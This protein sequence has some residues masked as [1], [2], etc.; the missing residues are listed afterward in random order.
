MAGLETRVPGDRLEPRSLGAVGPGGVFFHNLRSSEHRP[1][2]GF[3][4]HIGIQHDVSQKATRPTT[5]RKRK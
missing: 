4:I 5:R 1:P 3:D 2:L